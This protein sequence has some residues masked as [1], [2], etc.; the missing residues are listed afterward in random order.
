[1]S[2]FVDREDAPVWVRRWL[3]PG[4]KLIGWSDAC[5]DEMQARVVLA[6]GRLSRVARTVWVAT[7]IAALALAG[8]FANALLTGRA[9][10]IV[11]ILFFGGIMAAT[12]LVARK[13]YGER[14]AVPERASEAVEEGG[15]FLTNRRLVA[16]DAR[17]S[18]VAWSIPGRPVSAVA[19]E[20]FAEV[21]ISFR[22][23]RSYDV[24]GVEAPASLVRGLEGDRR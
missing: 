5:P 15:F 24:L 18:G 3:E 8:L 22:D 16:L 23:G 2:R 11:P 4:E 7:S 14:D 10:A 20:T 12:V 13:R 21:T 9:D 17:L 6:M 1:M 19:D